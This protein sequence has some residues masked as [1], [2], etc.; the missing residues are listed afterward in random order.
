MSRIRSSPASS[1]PPAIRPMSSPIGWNPGAKT[2][3]TRTVSVSRI[4]EQDHRV[5]PKG[6]RQPRR[7]D[8]PPPSPLGQLHQATSSVEAPGEQQ[9]A[10]ARPGQHAQDHDERITQRQGRE[11][12]PFGRQERQEQTPGDHVGERE[13]RDQRADRR[14]C[15]VCVHGGHADWR[16]RAISAPQAR[17]SSHG[18]VVPVGRSNQSDDGPFAHSEVRPVEA[19][20][21]DAM[22]S[23]AQSRCDGRGVDRSSSGLSGA[24]PARWRTT[25]AVAR[26]APWH[27][28]RRTA[29]PNPASGRRR[30]HCPR[31][32]RR[33]RSRTG[34]DPWARRSRRSR[35]EPTR[36][37]SRS[38]S[39]E[40]RRALTPRRP[41]HAWLPPLGR[42]GV[43]TEPNRGSPCRVQPAACAPS[44]G[45][46]KT[47]VAMVRTSRGACR[48]K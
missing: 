15:G 8:P 9:A 42:R 36:R 44:V 32:R 33:I 23:G 13:E 19:T 40:W 17:M 24:P 2:G 7:R 10:Q 5:G 11:L 28:R 39:R 4:V 22:S 14:G 26:P 3:E 21:E 31:P 34:R 35:P 1:I 41:G 29:V 20:A 12:E 27:G 38:R 37:R 6:D 46:S 25:R 45:R 43:A 30:C 16:S 18:P 47:T 48:A